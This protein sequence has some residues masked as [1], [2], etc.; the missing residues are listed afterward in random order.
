MFMRRIGIARLSPA[1][2]INRPEQARR[3][4]QLG[5]IRYAIIPK[6]N[7]RLAMFNDVAHFR[8]SEVEIH[9]HKHSPDLGRGKET[10]NV[11]RPVLTE[12]CN[13]LAAA[14]SKAMESSRRRVD[15]ID[16]LSIGARLILENQS[17]ALRAS[18]RD[19]LKGLVYGRGV[20]TRDLR[21][22]IHH[23]NLPAQW[24]RPEI[25]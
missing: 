14:D 23:F 3:Q 11:L 12:D 15:P 5:E 9:R 17:Y 16:Q 1:E 2:L 6:E 7:L 13:R 19:R 21:H 10:G 4:I 22:K 25:A 18:I 8:R 24:R 20:G